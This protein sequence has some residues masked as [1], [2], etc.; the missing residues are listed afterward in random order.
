MYTS[1]IS[2]IAFILFQLFPREIIYLFGSGTEEYYQFA[3]KF[4]CIFLFFICINF[5]QPITSTFFTSIGKPIKG[6]FLSLTRQI[7]YLL[8]LIIILPLFSGIDGII[9]ACPA[10]NFIVA[11]TC[12]I[13]ISI[14]FKNMKQFELVEEHQNIHL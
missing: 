9:F 4:F 3:T 1:F 14:E 12:L 2:I 11:I 10:V 6:I 8:P 5:I 7:I 13:T